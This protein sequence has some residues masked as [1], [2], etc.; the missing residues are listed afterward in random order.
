MATDGQTP[1]TTGF[2]T[3]VADFRPS[4][5]VHL[6]G[7]PPPATASARA[8]MR[9]G[10]PAA[11]REQ[12]FAMRLIGSLEEVL[13]PVVAILDSLPAYFD[14]SLAPQD[15]L[16]LLTAWLGV[17]LDESQTPAEWRRVLRSALLLGRWRG[18][19]RGV[20]MTL[21]LAFPDLDFRV[22]DNGGV[23][24]PGSGEQAAEPP[25]EGFVVYCDT[26]M[27]EERM[28]AIA[29]VIDAA[30]PAHVT[31]RLRVKKPR[32]ARKKTEKAKAKPPAEAETEPVEKPEEATGEAPTK[33][34]RAAR[35]PRKR[36]TKETKPERGSGD[37]TTRAPGERPEGGE[38]E[39]EPE[40]GEGGESVEGEEAP[41]Q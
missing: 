36:R 14:T 21:E 32:G 28:P 40:D 29:R 1:Q 7:E 25:R 31:Y 8:Y 34:P 17:E 22:E 10:L 19:R 5:L 13:D 23:R 38:E 2:I 26:P 3:Q 39:H 11:Y 18:T 12:D 4:A 27:P 37:A 6:F 33:E 41:E 16:E 9:D 30:R 20:E 15:L 24:W 35:E